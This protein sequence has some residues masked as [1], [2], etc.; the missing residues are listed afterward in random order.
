[1]LSESASLDVCEATLKP[2]VMGSQTVAEVVLDEEDLNLLARRIKFLFD[3]NPRDAVSLLERDYPSAFLCF[4][5]WKAKTSYSEGVFW[6]PILESLGLSGVRWERQLGQAFQ[7]CL[8]HLGLLQYEAPEALAYVTPVLF[9]GG[10]PDSCV[11]SFFRHVVAS[12][13][14]DGIV[15]PRAIKHEVKILRKEDA[16]YRK[17]KA[18]EK[19]LRSEMSRIKRLLGRL[20]D[21][22]S[23]QK[24]L[25]HIVNQHRFWDPSVRV[26][27]LLELWDED[28]KRAK[29][30]LHINEEANKLAKL[31][32]EALRTASQLTAA[33]E[34]VLGS[35][36]D[37]MSLAALY[38]ELES[39]EERCR[40]R[41]V[42]FGDIYH[43]LSDVAKSTLGV[44]WSTELGQELKAAGPGFLDAVREAIT[45]RDYA[46][47][48]LEAQG[49][50][51]KDVGVSG[52]EV[53]KDVWKATELYRLRPPHSSK[54]PALARVGMAVASAGAAAGV[55][56]LRLPVFISHTGLL[57]GSLALAVAAL[58]CGMWASR[59]R[60][61]M[62]QFERLADSLREALN[63]IQEVCPSPVLTLSSAGLDA[64]KEVCGLVDTFEELERDTLLV[65]EQIHGVSNEIDRLVERNPL[66]A[67]MAGYES[68]CL[69]QQLRQAR[70]AEEE[71]RRAKEHIRTSIDPKIK[72][73]WLLRLCFCLKSAVLGRRI[74]EFGGGDLQEGLLNLEMAR[75]D[76][77]RV[78]ELID[79]LADSGSLLVELGLEE[80]A[81]DAHP[82]YISDKRRELLDLKESMAER[83]AE[84]IEKKNRHRLAFPPS[85]DEPVT[86]YILFGEDSAL[87][88]LQESVNL[89]RSGGKGRGV[90]WSASAEPLD[91][92]A[93]RSYE[94]WAGMLN[95]KEARTVSAGGWVRD[96]E[97][98]VVFRGSSCDLYLRLPEQRLPLHQAIGGVVLELKYGTPEL[99]QTVEHRELM[100]F[101][102]D[103]QWSR[104]EHIELPLLYPGGILNLNIKGKAGPSTG[105][106]THV[107]GIANDS[108]KTLVDQEMPS[109]ALKLPGAGKP[110]AFFRPS[111]GLE[112]TDNLPRDLV[113]VVLAPSWRSLPDI[114]LIA[115]NAMTGQW[116]GY[117]ALCLDLAECA[118]TDI[119]F[120]SP[121]G[122]LS[123]KVLDGSSIQEPYLDGE[124]A[125]ILLD[126]LPVY[127][128]TLPSLVLCSNSLEDISDW[129]LQITRRK[130][131]H[132]EQDT[133]EQMFESQELP[134]SET[135]VSLDLESFLSR[136]TRLEMSEVAVGAFWQQDSHGTGQ[137]PELGLGQEPG[138]E[139]VT[140][141]LCLPEIA[142]E[143]PLTVYNLRLIGPR[144]RRF[145]FA[146]WVIE[147]IDV[148]FEPVLIGPYDVEP[149]KVKVILIA[150]EDVEFELESRVE[151]SELAPGFASM[152][153]GSNQRAIEGKLHV[154]ECKVCTLFIPVP[155]M[156]VSFNGELLDSKNGHRP[157]QDG[158][159]IELSMKDLSVSDAPKLSIAFHHCESLMIDWAELSLGHTK[160]YAT[161]R[162][163]RGTVEFGL[164]EFLD[165]L[166]VLS[167]P[168]VFVVKLYS[169]YSEI[170]DFLPVLRVFTR[171]MVT[172]VIAESRRDGDMV[173]VALAWQEAG[174]E[175]HPV[176]RLWP[177]C[178]H[179]ST[180][181]EVRIPAG[182]MAV[183]FDLDSAS[184]RPGPYFLHFTGASPWA[185]ESSTGPGDREGLANQF[186]A[187]L[188]PHDSGFGSLAI[189]WHSGTISGC[190]D[191]GGK[192]RFR[193]SYIWL[194][195]DD[196]V[197]EPL[198]T[199]VSGEGFSGTVPS[200]T[201]ARTIAAAIFNSES[202]VV[203]LNPDL[204]T[205]KLPLE[206]DMFE[207]LLECWGAE[208]LGAIELV[209]SMEE[210]SST[211]NGGLSYEGLQ[212]RQQFPPIRYLVRGRQAAQLLESALD[213]RDMKVTLTFPARTYTVPV[214]LHADG[215][216]WMRL[217]Q[218]V[219]CISCNR[220]FPNQA[221]WH[222]HQWQCVGDAKSADLALREVPLK[223][224]LHWR[225][226]SDVTTSSR[227]HGGHT[228]EED[229]VFF[230]NQVVPLARL[231]KDRIKSR[232]SLTVA[233]WC[234]AQSGRKWVDL[235]TEGSGND[236][237]KEVFWEEVNRRQGTVCR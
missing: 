209:P 71:A 3:T 29:A 141:P 86:R 37:I 39:L 187:G 108:G 28:G 127:V 133:Q 208:A 167:E 74:E 145:I 49:W 155:H 149:S 31:R 64:L 84:V 176:V 191:Q 51:D 157:G 236:L 199:T 13:A 200:R 21:F 198:D 41:K 138:Q 10:I 139:L 128:Q 99:G 92:L 83:L 183:S 30:L 42:L 178:G 140:I 24:T 170:S 18:E 185:S 115:D 223:A 36:G 126:S 43:R 193:C 151:A 230:G 70:L 218:G 207:P 16:S 137:E 228:N 148:E 80:E 85:V 146:F 160:Q 226:L 158:K 201:L 153:F 204:P 72:E 22:H 186:I 91:R 96:S 81:F 175:D 210:G 215:T 69:G 2:F 110:V 212:P 227:L 56:T 20:E 114:R 60:M 15:D 97:P 195:G 107:V 58:L 225:P 27:D 103:E 121:E 172:D 1:M 119:V 130:L 131:G 32:D 82:D 177:V 14:R 147:D 94:L 48:Q 173:N 135:S 40:V 179:Q 171:W 222:A 62:G 98:Q 68:V 168:A 123:F 7:R 192:A 159:M 23:K 124:K 4:M 217:V 106:E 66:L 53:G 162:V 5:V 44:P 143:G 213:G 211:G 184:Y 90:D 33:Q 197:M 12:F 134:Q 189:D 89:L 220:I 136:S 34:Q 75:A 113:W 122:R 224:Y 9:H 104:T 221:D 11:D 46:L 57:F 78:H 234:T 25:K 67:G 129:H 100:V 161:R 120:S 26:L 181:L 190:R 109:W 164:S 219:R 214:R 165:S 174:Y 63:A 231:D 216:G 88:V 79:E 156:S 116:A 235:L 206:G 169:G 52:A 194:D 61:E 203:E 118:G 202:G 54:A 101:R 35:A 180:S 38:R 144:R 45:E 150:P 59:I 17:H 19:A 125:P 233:R 132:R 93:R 142:P 232:E 196:L 47:G 182:Q 8:E 205:V 76:L 77:P 117:R 102:E 111:S 50:V 73:T 55:V 65:E 229:M 87:K 163:D 112:I 188:L 154:D 95:E 152:V 166:R 237:I 6:P 105:I